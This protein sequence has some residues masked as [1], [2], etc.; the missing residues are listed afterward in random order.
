MAEVKIMRLKSGEH[1]P[2]ARRA[3]NKVRKAEG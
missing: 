1:K 2:E 3:W